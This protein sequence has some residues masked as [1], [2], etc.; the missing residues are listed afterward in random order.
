[1]ADARWCG[2][3]AARVLARGG[4]G[5][6]VAA[7]G[8][9]GYLRLPGGFVLVVPPGSPRGPLT[10][11]VDGLVAP[12]LRARVVVSRSASAPA[13]A[14]GA[15]VISLGRFVDRDG[16]R[17][18]A[19]PA[20]RAPS[21]SAPAPAVAACARAALAA[22]PPPPDELRAGIATLAAGDHGGAVRLLAGLGDG[23]TPAGDD[24]L[25][26]HAAWRWAVGD[27][28]PLR[29]SATERC[30]PIGLAY[31][32]CAQRGELAPFAAEVL[33]AI[34]TG[35][36]HGAARLARR[37][38]EWGASSGAALIWGMTTGPW[39]RA[40][41]SGRAGCLTGAALRHSPAVGVVA[42]FAPPYRTD[43]PP[44]DRPRGG[45]TV[46]GRAAA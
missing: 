24:V 45:A 30:S 26:G 3:G 22:V 21:P 38:T 34:L 20:P 17:R 27:P 6:V 44:A 4:S 31:L 39:R 1:M 16:T 19:A 36:A 18:A 12:A 35:D 11:V 23:L 15:A 28:V 14:V 7:F 40:E 9:G 33:R 42:R 41:A 2:P 13:L 29:S 8:G 10:L 37:C 32:E 25:A 43:L 5:S 46:V